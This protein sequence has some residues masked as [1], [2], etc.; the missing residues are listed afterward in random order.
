MANKSP[1]GASLTGGLIL[2]SISCVCIGYGLCS[3]VNELE[4]GAVLAGVGA[5]FA[6]L[7]AILLSKSGARG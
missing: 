2:L 7:A 6:G 4:G 3:I 1:A 5:S